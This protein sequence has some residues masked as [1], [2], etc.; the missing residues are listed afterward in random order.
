MYQGARPDQRPTS[1][2]AGLWFDKFCD[3]WDRSWSLA[4]QGDVNPKHEWIKTVTNRRVGD[5]GQI[6]EFASRLMGLAKARGGRTRV[7]RTSSRFVTGL[8]RSHPVENGFAWH[9]T[10]GTPYLP[11]SSVK[12][13]VLAWA[14]LDAIPTPTVERLLGSPGKAG[15]VCFTDAVPTEPVR[16]E[17]DVMTPH[18][19]GWTASDPPGDWRSPTPIPFLVTAGNTPFLFGLV[20]R[21]GMSNDDLD[22]VCAWLC[23]ALA[24]EGG[25]AKTSVGYGRFER[26]LAGEAEANARWSAR[27]ENARQERETQRQAENRLET[28]TVVER[29]IEEILERRPDKT[30][31]SVTAIVKEVEGGRWTGDD[32]IEVAT[33]LKARMQ[34]EKRW[35][36]TSRRKNPAKDRDYQYTLR[37]MDWLRGA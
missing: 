8:G 5:A 33:W 25:G 9:P 7:L 14:K 24:W 6:G 21:L 31:A 26:D 15:V 36:E 20:P 34:R 13:L 2:H 27:E 4:G 16:L 32:R 12:G 35:R 29:E 28:L 11:G 18:Y 22:R 3:Q 1:G 37:V 19:A 17:A 10:L 30:M 23:S